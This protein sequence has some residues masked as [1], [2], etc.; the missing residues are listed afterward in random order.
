MSIRVLI[1]EDDR[2]LGGLL[3]QYL[4][5]NGFVAVQ[6][7]NGLEAR[8]ELAKASYEI[9]VID[10]MMPQEDGFTLAE[11]LV[12]SHPELPFLFLTARGAKQDVLRGLK[13]G[14]DDYMTKPFDADELIQRI[15]NI[16]RR[17]FPAPA[18]SIPKQQLAIG[19]FTFDPDNLQLCSPSNAYTLTEKEAA[20]LH[21]LYLNRGTVIRR[22][23]ILDHLWQQDDFFSGRSMDVFITRLRKHLSA[24]P[25]ISIESIRGIGFRFTC[26]D[27]TKQ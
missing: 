8:V 22:K 16:L 21:Y 18:T 9:A 14:A 19:L 25:T 1:V 26:A 2:D 10:L 13:L 20:L 5:M 15:Y 4:Q 27:T 12:Q 3:G 24:D 17:S 11:K 7:F 23:T 6:A